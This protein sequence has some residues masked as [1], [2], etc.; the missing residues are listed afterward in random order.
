M[1]SR[2]SSAAAH[3][4][5]ITGTG[6]ELAAISSP[7]DELAGLGDDI[8]FDLDGLE[9]IDGS[10]IKLPLKVFNMKG[11]DGA[12]DPIPPNVFFDTVTETT[13]KRLDLVLLTLHKT[14]L[15]SAFNSAESRTEIKCRS[16]DRQTGTMDDGTER[17]CK[18]CPDAQWRTEAGKRTRN[19]GPVYNVF[20]IERDTKQPCAIRFKRTSLPVIQAHL[21][22]HHIGRRIVNG[23]R[24]NYPLFSFAVT[25]SLKMSDDGKYAI[26]VLERGPVLD[27]AEI[28]MAAES[29]KFVREALLPELAKI[30]EKDTDTGGSDSSASGNGAATRSED[31]SDAPA[32]GSRF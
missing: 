24:A 19:C 31:F 22:K 29:A 5:E 6:T 20:A 21:N 32:D 23:K 9:E 14:H 12:G 25:A 30:E 26:P 4:D 7:H 17:P 13:K 1:A 8:G 18:G 11:T 28:E 2:K 10:D 16:F 15:W 27:R 3:A